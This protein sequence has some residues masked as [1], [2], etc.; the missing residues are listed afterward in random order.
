MET[1]I[2]V[3][4]PTYRRPQLLVNC[5]E[6]LASQTLDNTN[7]EIIVVS[8]GPD[9]ATGEA[10]AQWHAANSGINCRYL[11]TPGK[12]GPAAARNAGS[13]AASAPL[14]AFTDD[15]CLPASDWLEAFCRHYRGEPHIAMT[16]GVQV[17]LSPRPTDFEWNTAQLQE[18]EFVTANCCCTKDALLIVGGFDEAFGMAWRE[19]S[20]LQFKLMIQGIPI[21]H[22]EAAR[23][24]HPVRAAPWGVSLR[25]QKK[26][27][28]N[29]LL[30]KKYPRLFRQKIQRHPVWHYYATVLLFA[31]MCT[32][33]VLDWTPWFQLAL[34]GWLLCVAVFTCKRLRMTSKSASHIAEMTVTSLLIPFIAIYWQWYGAI[35]YR[36][37]LF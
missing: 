12:Q 30:Y 24:R 19:D 34:I 9:T 13:I 25:E 14:I 29:A 22:V 5:L 3:V 23:V 11:S 33:L 28:Y 20:E 10:V 16:G 27:Q 31:A 26:G 17:P 1:R 8:D 37:L 18:A 2:S 6:A 35:K 15:D 7:F 21:V 36:V 4:I 32:A